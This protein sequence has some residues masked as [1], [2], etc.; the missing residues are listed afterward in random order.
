MKMHET[1]RGRRNKEIKLRLTGK[2][3]D[4]TKSISNREKEVEWKR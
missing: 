3:K 1:L 2:E 4:G